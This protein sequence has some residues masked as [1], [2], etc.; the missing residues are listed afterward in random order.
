MQAEETV[1]EELNK[2]LQDQLAS[3][4]AQLDQA[5]RRNKEL[6]VELQRVE[7]QRERKVSTSTNSN[8]SR[9]STTT[10]LSSNFP[11]I[12]PTYNYY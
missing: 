11:L 4:Y 12:K 7:L 3:A 2:Q 5:Q 9:P 6:E 1:Q 10:V 8:G